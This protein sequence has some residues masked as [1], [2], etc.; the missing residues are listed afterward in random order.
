MRKSRYQMVIYHEYGPNAKPTLSLM[1]LSRLSGVHPS[2]IEKLGR[3]SVIEP[4]ETRSGNLR[5]P[6]SALP[7][8]RRG[9]RLHRDLNIEWASLGLVLDLLER[10]DDLE[11]ALASFQKG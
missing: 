4:L 2:L 9:L 5:F 11:Q 3:R 10:I 6:I 1:E 8:L 7:R